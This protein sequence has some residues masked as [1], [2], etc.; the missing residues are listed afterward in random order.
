MPT[1]RWTRR[2]AGLATLGLLLTVLAG[3]TPSHP[4]STFDT[5][6]PVS[7]SQANLFYVL[8]WVGVIVFVAVTVALIYVVIRYRR[9]EG[10]ED[11]EQ[12][13]GHSKLE[14]AWTVAPTLLL[15]GIAVPTVLTIFD[16]ANSPLPPADGGL[17]VEATGH[18][19]W[20]E[21]EYPEYGITTANELHIPVGEPINFALNSVDVIHSFWVPKLAGKVDM[22][23]NNDNTMWFQA[24]EPGEY[25]G[26]CAEFC[27]VSHADMRLKVVALPRADFD[28]WVAAQQAP[29]VESAD[30]LAQAGKEIFFSVEA[31][32]R[33]CH[34][35]DGSSARGRIGP[36]LTHFASR[37]D[38]AGGIIENSQQNLRAWL[39]DPEE[40]KPAN[41][42]GRDGIVYNDPD[43]ALTEPEISALIAYLRTLE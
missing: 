11:P 14:I 22:V 26:Q 42:M 39:E 34:T 10:D 8:F 31:G 28:A 6:G 7:R 35:I 4:Q 15:A 29:A 20:F 2:V 3:C 36:N 25:L 30:P 37:S 1:G 23:P 13:H 24:R 33:G 27:G 17:L 19:W 12:L 9:K 16:N 32:C 21:F 41:K 38:F 43:R 5:L 18:Q 40:M